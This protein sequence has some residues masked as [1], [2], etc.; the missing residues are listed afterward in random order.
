MSFYFRQERFFLNSTIVITFQDPMLLY[1]KRNLTKSLFYL[2]HHLIRTLFTSYTPCK[3]LLM[4]STMPSKIMDFSNDW[5]PMIRQNI[6]LNP[7][8][9]PT[10]KISNLVF[11]NRLFIFADFLRGSFNFADFLRSSFIF[12][13]FL[14]SSIIFA[15]FLCSPLNMNAL[16]FTLQTVSD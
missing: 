13:D 11:W 1:V 6:L 8:Q 14:R 10:L 4:L 12:A 3:K 9:P 15:D 7:T 2:I 16:T 5:L